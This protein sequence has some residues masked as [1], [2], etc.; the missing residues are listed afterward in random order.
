MGIVSR[1]SLV[2]TC[3]AFGVSAR[4]TPA[5]QA[6]GCTLTGRAGAVA[7]IPMAK[8]LSG[9]KAGPAP[10]ASL[11]ILRQVTDV[12]LPGR[13]VRFDYQSEDLGTGRLYISHMRDAHVVVF[14]TRSDRI[15]GQIGETPGVTGVWAVP[16][17]HRVYA[18]VTGRHYV[19]VID[20][21]SLRIK[22][23]LGPIGFPDGIAYVPEVKRVFVSDEAGGG[24]LVIDGPGDKVIGRVPLGGEAGNTK[25]DEGSGC[26]L[27]AVQTLN[28]VVA[29]DPTSTKVVG[30]YAVSG[31]DHPHGMQVDA[32]DRLL[33]IANQGNATLEVVDLRSMQVSDI[34]KVGDDPDVLAFDPEWSRLYVATEKGGLWIYDVRGQRLITDGAIDLPHAHTVSVDPST[35]RVYLPLENL[36]GRPI[37]RVL[38]GV[39]SADVAR[40]R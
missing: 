4:A 3:G 8:G 2:V 12:E 32:K 10:R 22:A 16:E 35:H 30:R 14:D 31:A 27:V 29:I 18:S 7:E 23:T 28:Q 11:P 34:A 40:P 15:A 33:F 24:E 20:T 5:V 17:L 25:Y 9:V 13:P 1:A 39:R 36:N 38:L 6:R 21:D 37:L 26:I 19:A